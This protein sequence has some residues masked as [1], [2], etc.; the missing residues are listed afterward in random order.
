MH[1]IRCI[2]K[3]SQR[4]YIDCS[5]LL[6]LNETWQGKSKKKDSSIFSVI[7]INWDNVRWQKWKIIMAC[8]A[9]RILTGIR[10]RNFVDFLSK[11]FTMFK[12]QLPAHHICQQYA[13]KNL[14]FIIWP[15]RHKSKRLLPVLY[16]VSFCNRDY[17][18]DIVRYWILTNINIC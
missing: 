8:Y 16:V 18:V 11:I 3:G 17:K 7:S 15:V 12:Y 9:A 4:G 6:I 5:I 10:N 13:A 14:Y 2:D 1:F